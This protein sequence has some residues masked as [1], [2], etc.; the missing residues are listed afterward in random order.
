[1]KRFLVFLLAAAFVM[2][3]GSA[4]AQPPPISEESNVWYWDAAIGDWVVNPGPFEDRD[5][6]LFRAGDSAT[7]SCNKAEWIVPVEI[8]ASIATWINF[9]LDWTQFH[10]FIRKP[11]IYAGDCIDACISANGDVVITYDGFEDLQPEIAGNNPIPV[12]YAIEDGT[13][14][15]IRDNNWVSAADLNF[16]ES[17]LP[18]TEDLHNGICW[19]LWNKIEVITCNSSCNY[20]DYANITL[21]L[22]NQ[23]PWIV[24]ATGE[25]GF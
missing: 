19:K 16:I 25:W 11:G 23:K 9:K 13:Y 8:H 10:W 1:M 24:F 6:R 7:G 3:A 2:A 12:W 21:T 22:Q 14:Y 18:D 5:A 20:S 15:P 17:L 4:F